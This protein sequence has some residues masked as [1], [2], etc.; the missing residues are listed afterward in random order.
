MEHKLYLVVFNYNG[1]KYFKVGITSKTDVDK[2]FKY[3]KIKY[4]LTEFKI[5]R[6]SWFKTKEEAEEEEQSLFN[7]I[8]DKFPENNYVDKNGKHYFHNKWFSEKLN[9]ITE[10]RKYN[11]EEAQVAY[12][13]IGENGERNHKDLF[14]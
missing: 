13:F 3:A 11:H 1:S 8:I 10:I 9:G 12:E 2:R 4:G 6:S 14:A 7:I 5:R